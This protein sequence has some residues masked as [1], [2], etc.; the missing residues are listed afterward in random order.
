M[1]PQSVSLLLLYFYL[2]H[3][4]RIFYAECSS[5]DTAHSS[6]FWLTVE[7]LESKFYTRVNDYDLQKH[8]TLS[9]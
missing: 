9:N 4:E 1:F 8:Q 5:W 2:S 3:D 6:L 7:T